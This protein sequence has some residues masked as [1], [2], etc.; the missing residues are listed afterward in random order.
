MSKHGENSSNGVN[1]LKALFKLA[2][3]YKNAIPRTGTHKNNGE[4]GLSYAGEGQW[5]LIFAT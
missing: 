3:N 5:E 2:R 4:L 1:F